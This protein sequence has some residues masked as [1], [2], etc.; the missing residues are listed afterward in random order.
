MGDTPRALPP[1]VLLMGPTASGKTRLALD[2]ARVLP[3]EVVSVDSAQVYRRLRSGRLRV[4]ARDPPRAIMDAEIITGFAM[5]TLEVKLSLPDSLAQ[6]AQAAGLLAPEQLERL[7]R[8]ALRAKRVE[9]LTAARATLAANPLPPMT[10]EE[11]QA[12]IDAYRAR[13]RRASG[14]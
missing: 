14:T 9:R 13:V 8:E 1:V 12:E 2:L 6:E 10:P 11:I 7:V 3:L 4:C 5:T